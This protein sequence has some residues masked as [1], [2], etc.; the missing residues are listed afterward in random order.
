MI[1]VDLRFQRSEILTRLY[2]KC[3]HLFVNDCISEFH[4]QNRYFFAI[5]SL[6][7]SNLLFHEQNRCF[8]QSHRLTYNNTLQIIKLQSQLQHTINWFHYFV[9]HHRFFNCELIMNWPGC[10]SGLK[11]KYTDTEL[12]LHAGQYSIP[13]PYLV[14]VGRFYRSRKMQ[15]VAEFAFYEFF[16]DLWCHGK[17]ATSSSGFIENSATSEVA[18]SAGRPVLNREVAIG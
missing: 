11:V 9:W 13:L 8:S 7:F 15:D 5:I 17:A 16:R 18:E 4:D 14:S 2:R 12:I 3:F 6:F 1:D 10:L